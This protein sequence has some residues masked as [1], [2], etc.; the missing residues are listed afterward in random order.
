MAAL[1]LMPDG[2]EGAVDPEM[3]YTK[4]NCIGR[5]RLVK[6]WCSGTDCLIQ[7]VVVLARCTKGMPNP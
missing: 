5:L 6:A 7:V 3:L 4:Q 1:S 2:S